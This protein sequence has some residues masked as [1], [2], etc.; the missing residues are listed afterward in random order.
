MRIFPRKVRFGGIF[1]KK[2]NENTYN[3]LGGGK[4][5]LVPVILGMIPPHSAY[6][7]P[8]YGGRAVLFAKKPSEREYISDINAAMVRLEAD[9]D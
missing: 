9:R 5:Q 4:Q 6:N 1:A 2:K 3:V 7:E 8:L